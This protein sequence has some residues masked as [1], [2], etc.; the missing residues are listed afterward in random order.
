MEYLKSS[1]RIKVGAQLC[2]L[3]CNC[4]RTNFA[5]ELDILEDP[6]LDAVFIPLTNSLHFEWAVRAIRADKHVLV[7]KPSV[8]NST[9]A[10]M[11]FSMPE[12]SKPNAPVLLEAFHFRFHP[13]VHKFRS[14]INSA[15]VVHV[16]TDN[17]I[18][19]LFTAKGIL[20]S[21]TTSRGEVS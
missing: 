19:W 13:A 9:E 12:I 20:S 18:P 1:L 16:H 17:M 21:T 11:L 7:E 5:T 6:E 8:S 3:S 2:R 15:D 14:L 4:P 10:N